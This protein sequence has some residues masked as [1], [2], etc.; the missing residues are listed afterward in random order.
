MDVRKEIEMITLFDLGVEIGLKKH[1]AGQALFEFVPCVLKHII[2]IDGDVC[3][4]KD[5]QLQGTCNG[6]ST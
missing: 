6:R 4:D 1:V 2:A 5:P 3:A